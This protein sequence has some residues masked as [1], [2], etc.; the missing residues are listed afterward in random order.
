MVRGRGFDSRRLHQIPDQNPAVCRV[1]DFS[2]ATAARGTRP[3]A[4]ATAPRTCRA[5]HD[6]AAVRGHPGQAPH[7][8]AGKPAPARPERQTR[9]PD[10][11]QGASIAPFHCRPPTLAGQAAPNLYRS[12]RQLGA[13]KRSAV[14][15]RGRLGDSRACQ[16]PRA[17]GNEGNPGRPKPPSR[18]HSSRRCPIPARR[19]PLRSRKPLAP[20]SGAKGAVAERGR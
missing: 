11:P 8:P 9:F 17:S 5:R 20:S 12:R 7:K 16:W 3:E 19:S 2:A 1:F 18:L 10:P 14:R 6:H 13:G 15:G 4:P